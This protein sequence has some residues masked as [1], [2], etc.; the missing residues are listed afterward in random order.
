MVIC[1]SPQILMMA[2][3]SHHS[4]FSSKYV[5]LFIEKMNKKIIKV[6]AVYCSLMLNEYQLTTLFSAVVEEITQGKHTP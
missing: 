5:E 6:C 2:L 3:Y 4:S 1:F